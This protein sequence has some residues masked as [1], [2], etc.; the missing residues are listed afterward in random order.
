MLNESTPQSTETGTTQT[1][2]YEPQLTLEPLPEP[3]SKPPYPCPHLSDEEVATYLKPLYTRAWSLVRKKTSFQAAT[4]RPLFLMKRFTFK[5]FD[6]TMAFV[7]DVAEAVG[8][9]G[10]SSLSVL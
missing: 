10:V 7:N 8:K 6:H 9:E 4:R 3:P 5:S 1:E 2:V